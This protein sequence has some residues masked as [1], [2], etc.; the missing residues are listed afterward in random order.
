M[1]SKH[2]CKGI[3]PKSIFI[4]TQYLSEKGEPGSPYSFYY[5]LKFLNRGYRIMKGIKIITTNIAKNDFWKEENIE[6]ETVTDCMHVVNVYPEVTG[7]TIEGFGGAFTEAS[8]VNYNKLGKK[9]QD[10]FMEAYFGEEG[11]RYNLCRTHINS[12]DFALGNY[13]Y[14]EE[15]DK[16]LET[17]SIAHDEKMIIPMIK[18]AIKTSKS[19]ISFLA[20]PWSPPA[21]MKTNG[22]MNHGGSLKKEYYC[23]WA[24]YFARY[25]KA[26][27]EHGIHIE[28]V[29][30]QN[31]PMANQTWDSCIYTAEE[32]Q[33]FVKDYLGPI[34]RKEGLGHVKILVWDH[35]KEEAY[36]R[37][38]EIFSDKA[39][40]ELISG[41][42]VHWYTGDHFE[43]LEIIRQQYPE[44]EILFTEGCV[45]Y[46]RFADA[47][48]IQKAEMYAH[49]MIGNLKSGVNGIIDWNLLLD[50][51]GGPNHA[52]NFCAAPVMLSGNSFEKRLSYYY[53]GHFSRYIKKGARKIA[54]TRYTDRIETVGFINPDG[55]RVLILLNKQ[56][57]AVDVTIREN[58]QGVCLTV[59]PHSIVTAVLPVYNQYKKRTPF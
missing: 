48:E 14:I 44:M 50:E 46:S 39:A 12:C 54:T 9:E 36:N 57:E 45:E 3:Q 35:N 24:R 20:S 2:L 27:E 10:S 15:G 51:E 56:N 55:E 16:E 21:F 59:D 32:E 31:E 47:K 41:V 25:I 33:K 34:L 40:R 18:E 30:V 52:G 4:K 43:A 26:Y 19:G 37:V 8:A 6:V 28:R 11:L 38:R 42:A 29:T 7:Q 53:I 49:D 23:A 5:I 1:V 17:F 22:N 13:S 58:G